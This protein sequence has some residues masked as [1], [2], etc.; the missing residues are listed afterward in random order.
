MGLK[1]GGEWGECLSNHDVKKVW[2][3][4][5]GTTAAE[6]WMYGVPRIVAQR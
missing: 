1:K 4:A 6:D 5:T 3:G 2:I